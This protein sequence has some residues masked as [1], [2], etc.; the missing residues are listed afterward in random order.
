TAQLEPRAGLRASRNLE[1]L[2]RLHRGHTHIAAERQRRERQRP[3]AIEIVPL[4]MEKRVF[5]HVDDDVVIA[6]RTAG[7]SVLPLAVAAPEPLHVSHD[8]SR[9]IWIAVSAPSYDSS[10]EISRSYRRSAPRCGPPR[11]RRPPNTSPKPKRSPRL[12]KI[13]SN[14]AKT[15]GSNPP[16]PGPAPL[17]PACPKRLYSSRFCASARTAYASAASLKRSSAVWSPGFRSGWYLSA[18]L[19]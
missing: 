15:V 9:G 6:G 2:F 8:S 7:R 16:A 14:P 3:L 10:N 12:P 13:S 11:R 17:T 5:L 4:A 19:R 1:L 18:S